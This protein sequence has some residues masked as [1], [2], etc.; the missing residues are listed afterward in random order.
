[1]ISYLYNSICE[2]T[3]RTEAIVKQ[4]AEALTTPH[5][6][7]L[8]VILFFTLLIGVQSKMQAQVTGNVDP[9]VAQFPVIRGA[10]DPN[11]TGSVNVSIPLLTI[12]GIQGLD[13]SVSLNYMDGNGVPIS[14]SA[15][16]VGL[17]WNLQ[18]YEIVCNP[19]NS[20]YSAVYYGY[21]TSNHPPDLYHLYYPGGSTTF[22]MTTSGAGMPVHWSGIRIVGIEDAQGNYQCFVVYGMD[23]TKYVF[24]DRLMKTTDQLLIN[25]HYLS[26]STPSGSTVAYYYVYKL[27]AILAPDYVD[28]G[29]E[30]YMPGD[31]GTDHGAWI[32]LSYS[33]LSQ[34]RTFF[35]PY[36]WE[37][38]DYLSSISTPI[39]HADFQLSA[40]PF[41]PFIIGALTS[42]TLYSLSKIVLYRNGQS[43]PVKVVDFFQSNAFKWLVNNND[44]SYNWSSLAVDGERMR[45][46][47]VRIM[48]IDSST[49]EPSYKFDYY[50]GSLNFDES[51]SSGTQ[52]NYLIDSWGYL[53]TLSDESKMFPDTTKFFEY[54]SLREITYPTGGTIRYV[55]T[56]N[57][58]QPLEYDND[59]WRSGGVTSTLP[60]LVPDRPGSNLAVMQGG[61]RIRQQIITDPQTGQQQIYSYSYGDSS[62]LY[63]NQQYAAIG[64]LS[65]GVGFLSTDPG[66]TESNV[67]V[68]DI[69][70]GNA[71]NEQVQY[72]DVT[73]TLPDSSKIVKYYTT[74]WSADTLTGG[75]D[76]KWMLF[77]RNGNSRITYSNQSTWPDFIVGGNIAF[78]PYIY[79]GSDPQLF[80][81]CQSNDIPWITYPY[82]RPTYDFV[83]GQ[84]NPNGLEYVN[85]IAS[86]EAA[87]FDNC[88]FNAIVVING[89]N[90][91]M[92]TIGG[93]LKTSGIDNNWKYGY[94]VKEDKLSKNDV[95]VWSKSYYYDMNLKNAQDYIMDL[96][97]SYW[98]GI[99][100]SFHY[101]ECSGQVLLTKSIVRKY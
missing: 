68:L 10:R 41:N 78:L 11:Y 4:I 59:Y 79:S 70:G 45:L 9:S 97:P 30:W 83:A 75:N 12:P 64:K 61:L 22:W 76:F 14:R 67:S 60:N 56:P 63:M 92:F 23:G 69:I 90:G 20:P 57:Y 49:T 93:Y 8:S 94:L 25:N 77:D 87:E 85:E 5:S 46:D 55:Y 16:W 52:C 39:Y 13:Y 40:G 19:V 100:A 66:P 96:A 17:G 28:G 21:D 53:D 51:Q 72:P 86:D 58:F 50:Y 3:N 89:G 32:K 36:D 35:Q 95:L 48:G 24:A 31:G 44:G 29:G 43:T 98:G 15:S 74:C 54:G 101:T 2:R 34:F 80:F 71:V 84:E 33:G 1:M 62:N 6:L 47:S 82:T 73:I 99:A 88:G 26:W 91:T 42:G 27:S 65:P 38:V 37:Q 18:N 81:S 7:S